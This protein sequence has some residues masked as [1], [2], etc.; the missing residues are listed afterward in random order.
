MDR[1]GGIGKEMSKQK[2]TEEF[3]QEL[4]RILPDIEIIGE[5]VNY[6][7]KIDFR[8]KRCGYVHSSLP[9]VLL[10]DKYVQEGCSKCRPNKKT[11]THEQFV[12]MIKDKI[13]PSIEIVGK[14]TGYYN[15]ITCRCKICG[16]I[17]ALSTTTIRYGGGC[18]KCQHEIGFQKRRKTPEQF[19]EE[20]KK[21]SLNYSILEP[22]K[23]WNTKL[24]CKC[25]VCGY[26]WEK[27]PSDLLYLPS[28]DCPLCGNKKA[29]D[30]QAISTE[31]F[32][33]KLNRANN[34]IKVVGEYYNNATKIKCY[35]MDCCQYFDAMPRNLLNRK[36]CPLCTKSRGETIIKKWLKEHQINYI[37]E[38][39]FPDLI[40]LGGG[41][42]RYD[43]YLPNMQT[44]IEYNGIQHERPEDFGGKGESFAKEQYNKQKRHDCIKREY[45]VLHNIKMIELWKK[46]LPNL[47]SILNNEL[48]TFAQNGE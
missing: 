32:A 23:N 39:T 25:N 2:T 5:Y 20:M 21:Y 3:K 38:K 10:H 22:Y 45:A 18:S 46:D 36:N 16:E 47:E 42:L 15:K 24:L 7:T 14:Y 27:S 8:C 37:K 43:F 41:K 4:S 44:I 28:K 34:R 6:H 9:A 1:K 48:I 33:V 35:C 11:L 26:E 30:K 19:E 12:E 13:N 17:S 40:G 29:H 31:E